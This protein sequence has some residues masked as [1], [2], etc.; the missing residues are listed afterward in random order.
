MALFP[1]D[2]SCGQ[3]KGHGGDF[4]AARQR[5]QLSANTQRDRA[6]PAGLERPQEHHRNTAAAESDDH[7]T[8]A[9]ALLA[10]EFKS[11]PEAGRGQVILTTHSPNLL[12]QFDADD[13]RVVELDGFRTRIG[14]GS[15][16]QREAIKERLLVPGELLT[17]DH[18]R[19][20]APESTNA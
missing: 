5:Q 17:V 1:S 9:I 7:S 15:Q 14:K 11:A 20:E 4:R 3:T 8:G 10:D 2:G 16:E 18:A 13:I 6:Q 19:I 12:D